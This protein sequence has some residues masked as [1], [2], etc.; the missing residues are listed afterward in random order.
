MWTHKTNTVEAEARRIIDD[1]C[2]EGKENRRG[3]TFRA[4]LLWLSRGTVFRTAPIPTSTNNATCHYCCLS[5]LRETH[6]VKA[7]TTAH[8]SSLVLAFMLSASGSNSS[9]CRTLFI[10]RS[11][12]S[13]SSGAKAFSRT[14]EECA[15]K[16]SASN[17][18]SIRWGSLTHLS[19]TASWTFLMSRCLMILLVRGCVVIS[20]SRKFCFSVVRTPFST[21][22][23]AR[24]S[25]TFRSW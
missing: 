4:G 14:S 9:S 17:R 24:R 25:R 11:Y 10:A 22:F 19:S 21:K 8:K 1:T 12:W 15:K 7:A 6:L 13:S 23:F 20:N 5:L 3:E 2:M 16:M 18:L